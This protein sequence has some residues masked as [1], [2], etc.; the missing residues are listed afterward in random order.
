MLDKPFA[1][2]LVFEE[3][4][5][6]GS[7]PLRLW[8]RPP[9]SSWPQLPV[10]LMAESNFNLVCA[11]SNANTANDFLNQ[12]NIPGVC[13]VALNGRELRR[14]NERKRKKERKQSSRIFRLHEGAE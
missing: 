5:K 14:L 12:L 6:G 3:R 11:S 9:L 8:P 13:S 4:N 10:T 1:Y 2:R 7:N